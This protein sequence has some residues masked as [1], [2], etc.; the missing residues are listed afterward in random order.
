M[1][2]TLLVTSCDFPRGFTQF[3]FVLYVLNIQDVIEI[4]R[5]QSN[6]ALQ[7]FN[8]YNPGKLQ[9]GA[10][11]AHLIVY[12]ENPTPLNNHPTFSCNRISFKTRSGAIIK[13]R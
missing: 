9:A 5:K 11:E 6:N 12:G 10:T 8:S 2:K 7:I 3:G 13:L 4:N 1:K